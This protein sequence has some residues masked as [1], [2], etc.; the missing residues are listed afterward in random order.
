[1]AKRT[2][3][4]KL[5]PGV[6][7]MTGSDFDARKFEATTEDDIRR[8][9]IEDGEDPDAEID[10]AAW[11]PTLAARRHMDMTQDEFASL[12]KIPVA[13]IRNWEQAR[14]A[15]DPSSKALMRIVLALTP[16][17]ARK[18]LAA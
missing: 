18:A 2:V 15:M 1:M 6:F 8:H 4:M 11:N 3:R 10:L 9:Q 14:V 16:R 17:T 7:K 13:T 12:L 5:E